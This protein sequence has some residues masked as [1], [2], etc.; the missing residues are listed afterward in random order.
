MA[1]KRSQRRGYV[2]LS[3]GA[4]AIVLMG[5]VGL[6]VD[7]GRM[8]IVKGEAQ[9]FADSAALAAVLELDGSSAGITRA[10]A[11]VTN[12]P[13]KNTFGTAAFSGTVVEYAQASTGAWTTNPGNP[14]GYAFARVSATVS[15]PIYFMSL[16]VSKSQ[17][18]VVASAVAGQVPKTTFGQGL[19]PFSPYA[20]N[21]TG[22]DFGLDIGKQYTLRWPSNPKWGNGANANVC[23]GDNSNN[24]VAVASAAG[25]SERGYIEDTSASLIRS[26]IVDD[27]QS[28]FRTVGDLVNMTGGAKQSQL[29]SLYERINQDSDTTSTTYSSYT[30]NG[31]RIIAAPIN[32]G[33]TPLGSN[34]RIVGIGAFLLTRTADYGNGGN[35]A[36]CAEYIG[37]WLQGSN[38]RCAVNVGSN[39]GGAFVARLIIRRF[40]FPGYAGD[41]RAAT[42]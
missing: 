31:R 23:Q 34:N 37:C 11:A 22:P 25:G 35:Q 8:Y 2:L 41:A 26:T 32:D 39:G 3:V 24:M 18:N 16:A 29:D 30:G 5:A 13:N 28:V 7:L 20:H 38:H 10:N 9:T 15:V 42:R 14:A 40:Q 1:T 27:V 4:A 21:L 33:G 12:N 17:T 6:A 19:F 36:W